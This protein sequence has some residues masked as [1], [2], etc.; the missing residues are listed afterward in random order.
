MDVFSISSRFVINPYGVEGLLFPYKV[1]LF[2]KYYGFYKMI[3]IT[4]ELQ[5]SSYIFFSFDYFYY[6]FID[7]A[8]HIIDIFKSE[9]R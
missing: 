6:H 5:D 7:I 3:S 2:P 1:F 9:E 8:S 4:A